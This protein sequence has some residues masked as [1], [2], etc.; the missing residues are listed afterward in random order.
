M[1]PHV[2]QALVD[3]FKSKYYIIQVCRDETQAVPGVHEVVHQP[4]S[5]MELFIL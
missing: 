5:N 2:T 3:H 1:P 4:M